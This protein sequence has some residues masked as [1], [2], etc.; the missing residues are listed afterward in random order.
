[1]SRKTVR[2]RPTVNVLLC[3]AMNS[4]VDLNFTLLL[5][6]LSKEYSFHCEYLSLV[7]DL[8]N[9]HGKKFDLVLVDLNP[10]LM[11]EVQQAYDYFSK[12]KGTKLFGYGAG[13][14][15]GN[16]PEWPED[17]FEYMEKLESGCQKIRKI[18]ATER[19]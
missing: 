15:R 11:H 9:L 16:E 2:T 8:N 3:V 12:E 17:R 13:W 1:M 18:L 6:A 5:E 4:S 19:Q 7:E 14:P 10:L